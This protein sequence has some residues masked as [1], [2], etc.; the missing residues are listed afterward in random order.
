MKEPKDD[1]KN[2]LAMFVLKLGQALR[3]L[4]R[5]R[6]LSELNLRVFVGK[7]LSELNLRVSVR[8]QS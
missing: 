3:L 8:T 2:P 1:L 6:S 7:S 4:V 5:T